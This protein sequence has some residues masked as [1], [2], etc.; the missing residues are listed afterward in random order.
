MRLL[1]YLPSLRTIDEMVGSIR[2][3]A[4]DACVHKL[5]IHFGVPVTAAV[6]ISY[7]TELRYGPT[8]SR[9]LISFTNTTGWLADLSQVS[10]QASLLQRVG[11]CNSRG[12]MQTLTKLS[13]TQATFSTDENTTQTN[14]QPTGI[15]YA[16]MQP[17]PGARRNTTPVTSYIRTN[18]PSLLPPT[19]VGPDPPNLY[20]AYG[21]KIGFYPQPKSDFTPDD[22]AAW[23]MH[24]L[25][26]GDVGAV[27]NLDARP[28]WQTAVE[29][30][31]ASAD[32]GAPMASHVG[33]TPSFVGYTY[34]SNAAFT[35][36]AAFKVTMT[37]PKP[38]SLTPSGVPGSVHGDT[39]AMLN[40]QVQ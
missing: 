23:I 35:T 19:P 33:W 39:Y 40:V 12:T 21:R 16:I 27:M 8:W 25:G 18:T 10:T 4:L 13:T 14:S 26:T 28:F 5:N 29:M 11:L 31:S 34:R 1:G 37:A 38:A 3:T 2:R 7:L 32:M 36:V 17:A 6:A 15:Q 22:S 9:D 30:Q 20:D 24:L